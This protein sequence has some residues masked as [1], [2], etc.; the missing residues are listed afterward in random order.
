MKI[1]SALVL[2]IS[3]V[4]LVG[5]NGC[6]NTSPDNPAVQ[7]AGRDEATLAR[8]DELMSAKKYREAEILLTREAQRIPN[9]FVV[10]SRLLLVSKAQAQENLARGEFL[11]SDADI[12]L[13]EATLVMLKQ[14]GINPQNDPPKDFEQIIRA[15]EEDLAA[16]KSKLSNSVTAACGALLSEADRLAKEAYSRFK[17][18]DRD[19]VVEG[20]IN[21]RKCNAHG[22]LISID[23]R[24]R[25]NNMIRKLL[26]LVNEDERDMILRSAGFGPEK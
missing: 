2:G 20:L 12:D 1:R 7:K 6:A 15:Q 16:L 24:S 18:N 10:Q 14:I 25:S 3:S 23:T 21:V 26:N 22:K 19:L 9:D 17:K 5:L 13:A 8:A 4:M 11:K